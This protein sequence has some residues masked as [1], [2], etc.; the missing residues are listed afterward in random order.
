M[1]GICKGKHVQFGKTDV[2][3]NMLENVDYDDTVAKIKYLKERVYMELAKITTRGQITLPIALRKKLNLKDGGKVAFVESAGEYKIINPTKFVVK[4]AQEGF[5]GLADEL[6]LKTEDDV[7][8][9]C[10]EIRKETWAK[11]N[12]NNG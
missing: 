2:R 8:E 10:R 11:S 7:F 1:S 12:T 4:E 3:Y 9:L 6:G 5:T